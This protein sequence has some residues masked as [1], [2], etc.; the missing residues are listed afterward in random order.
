MPEAH[1]TRA[2]ARG[3]QVTE[4]WSIGKPGSPAPSR[5]GTEH[6]SVSGTPGEGAGEPN[7]NDDDS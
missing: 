5:T 6:A 4:T 1:P 2:R 7:R 3:V